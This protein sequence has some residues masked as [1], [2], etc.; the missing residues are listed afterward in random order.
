MEGTQTPSGQQTRTSMCS[1]S[2]DPLAGWGWSGSSDTSGPST[3]EELSGHR[4]LNIKN[5]SH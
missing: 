4:R 2:S 1:D 3:P 5:K